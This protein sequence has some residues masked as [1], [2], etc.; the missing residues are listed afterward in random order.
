MMSR[1]KL[2]ARTLF[3]GVPPDKYQKAHPNSIII[4]E[5][6]YNADNERR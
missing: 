1:Q 6:W 3:K 2:Y 5:E 4:V